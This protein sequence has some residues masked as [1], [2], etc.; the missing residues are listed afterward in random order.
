[1]GIP[2]SLCRQLSHPGGTAVGT[3]TTAGT[4]WGNGADGKINSSLNF[5]G[6]NDYILTSDIVIGPKMSWNVWY[7]T[8]E[9]RD[10]FLVDQRSSEVGVQPVYVYSN[11]K[12]QF[13]DSTNGSLETSTGVFKFDGEWHMVTAVGT[14]STR[15][16]YYDG[17]E[18][19]SA[20]TGITPRT[21]RAIYIGTR[22]SLTSYFKD[23]IDDVRVYN[24]D[25]TADQIRQI[26][27]NG[28]INFGD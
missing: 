1:M 14:G 12:I 24:Y 10:E 7:K 20:S 26:Y 19:A 27:N 17:V 28:A 25:L 8:D 22:Y 3:C 2:G 18:V 9:A 21:A 15:K 5:N 11:G 4:A 16:I 6:S 23:Q 13:H